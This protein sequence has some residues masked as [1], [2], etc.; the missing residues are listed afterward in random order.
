MLRRRMPPRSLTS[1]AKRRRCGSASFVLGY[2]MPAE[3]ELPEIPVYDVGRDFP[4]ELARRVGVRGYDLLEMA[5]ARTPRPVLGLLDHLSRRWLVR[6]GSR[7]LAELDALAVLSRAPGLYYL[8]VHY[9]WGCT[10]AIKPTLEGHSARLLRTLDWNVAGI[11]RFVV[12]ARIANAPTATLPT[13]S[14]I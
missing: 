8:N 13:A 10:T 6:N 5:T 7:Y 14:R 9:E 3:A 1:T 12:A 11:G 2:A 4:I